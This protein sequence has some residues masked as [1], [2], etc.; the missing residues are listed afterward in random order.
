MCHVVGQVPAH[1]G[2]Q[3]VPQHGQ[4][5]SQVTILYFDDGSGNVF[6]LYSTP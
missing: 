2:H 5:G 6:P 4:E 1:Y 3:N